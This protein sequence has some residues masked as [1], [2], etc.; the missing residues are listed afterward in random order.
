MIWNNPFLIKNSEQI[1]DDGEYLALFDSSVL[2]II[3]VG[4]LEKVSYFV[5]SPGAGK[6]SFFR[7]ISPR[8]LSTVLKDQETY[9]DIYN[10]LKKLGILDKTSVN[11]LSANLS[12][13]RGYSILDEMFNNGRRKQMLL[14]LLNYRIVISFIRGIS[15]ILDLEIEELTMVTFARIP[16]ELLSLGIETSSIFRNAY[17][18]YKWAC[19]GEN[20]LCGYLDNNREQTIDL[21]FI[22]FSLNLLK[23]FEAGN[24]LINGEKRF[25]NTVLIFDDFHKLTEHQRSVVDEAVCLLK[26]S[27]GVWF[28]LRFEGLEPDKLIS[29]DSSYARDYNETIIIDDYWANNKNKLYEM[30]DNIANKRIKESGI[31]KSN[32]FA[33][34]LDN[35]KLNKDT[36]KSLENFI[37]NAKNEIIRHNNGKYD[38]VFVYIDNNI[39]N[40]YTK[41]IYYECI[42]IKNNRDQGGQLSLDLGI[43]V[44]KEEIINFYEKNKVGAEFYMC[45]ECEI[46]FYY[47]MDKIKA[48]SSNNIEQYLFHCSMLFD[49][50]KVKTIS[51][52]K[53]IKLN[54]K[55]QENILKKS[56][57]IRWNDIDYRYSNA[58][59]VKKFIE[60]IANIFIE[61]RDA[62]RNSY[63]GGS[64]T[65]LALNTKEIDLI[66]K[67][68]KYNNLKIVFLQCLESK[69]LQKLD[70]KNSEESIF[71]LNRWLCVRFN[72]P[73]A[74]G[75]WKKMNPDK[76][77]DLL[78]KTQAKD[79]IY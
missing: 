11:L 46:P 48:I 57:S 8:V 31:L 75:G 73:L 56:S 13:A 68:K 25:L 47:N 14:A 5:S 28:G 32:N 78:T 6:T 59:E 37:S 21:S 23:L 3:S 54:I 27:V 7:V 34:I 53:K 79:S 72:L 49:S 1:D 55:E 70:R 40:L 4:N 41:A 43:K 71:Y 66:T 12:C 76:L 2:G 20:E 44:E 63:S 51:K 77:N 29:K 30:L 24:I 26:S 74:Y 52:S 35:E 69:Y 22:H 64:Y 39:M 67:D 58:N 60:E 17:E 18:T 42:K 36:K 19:N 61:S 33:D 10:N 65:G 16:D 45:L 15:Q 38:D 62:E 50:Y 9:K